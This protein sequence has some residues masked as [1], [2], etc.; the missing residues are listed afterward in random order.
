VNA[1]KNEYL[2]S[3]NPNLAGVGGRGI[4]TNIE[5][6]YDRWRSIHASQDFG[7]SPRDNVPYLFGLCMS[8]KRKIILD[9][10]GFDPF[11]THNCAEDTDVGFQLRHRGYTLRYTPDA[12]VYHLH[13]D[14]EEKLKRNQYNWYF[15]GYLAKKRANLH[16]WTLFVGTFRRLFMDTFTDLVIRRDPSLAKLSL[17]MFSTKMTALINAS[18][19]NLV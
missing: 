11:F 5:N 19:S 14:D 9:I 2:A 17:S 4:E 1:I 15:W 7:P 6:I 3:S 8:F 16:P 12:I 13:N 10:G 18:R